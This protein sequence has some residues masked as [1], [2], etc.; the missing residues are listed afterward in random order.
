MGT[1]V[2]L[3]TGASTGI[4]QVTALHLAR[5]GHQVHA[6]MCSPER[7]GAP[8]LELAKTEG[9]KLTVSQLDVTD[10]A[11]VEKAVALVLAKAGASTY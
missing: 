9:L 10:P 2:S 4:G 1:T 3:I 5:A 7:G 11:S 8:L 6:T